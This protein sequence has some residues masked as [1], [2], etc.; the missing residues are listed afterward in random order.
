MLNRARRLLIATLT[1]STALA[2]AAP[3][4]AAPAVAAAGTSAPAKAPVVKAAVVKVPDLT[5]DGLVLGSDGKLW[6]LGSTR[7]AK[8]LLVALRPS[9][10]SISEHRLPAAVPHGSIQ[11][12]GPTAADNA[13]H[14]WLTAMITKGQAQQDVIYRFSVRTG[15]PSRLNVPRSCLTQSVDSPDGLYR[16]ADGHIWLTCSNKTSGL[17]EAVRY[18]PAG[19]VTATVVNTSQEASFLGPLAPGPHGSM[20]AVSGSFSGSNGI[21]EITATGKETFFPESSDIVFVELAGNGSKIIAVTSLNNS[22]GQLVSCY[23]QV[24]P[25]GKL[26]RIAVAPNYQGYNFHLVSTPAFDAHA[27]LWQF[28]TGRA[29][30]HAVNDEYF[31]EIGSKNKTQVLAFRLPKPWSN[32]SVSAAPPPV[33]A[34]GSIWLDIFQ[35]VNGILRIKLK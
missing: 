17:S 13:G 14:I 21:D 2:P 31:Y 15:A 3:A 22:K 11:Y 5:G 27:N 4:L 8:P 6:G 7:Q 16:S 32:T 24:E 9:R 25:N 33:I 1:A 30:G 26:R 34:D 20:W 23:F 19:K 18:T 10:L 12:P 29:D 28:M 35:P